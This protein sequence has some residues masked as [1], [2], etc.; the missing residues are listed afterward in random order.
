MKKILIVSTHI[1]PFAG[2]AE[3]VAWEIATGL[4]N[5]YEVH[6]LTTGPNHSDETS[7]GILI[8]R[9]KYQY[10]LSLYYSTLGKKYIDNLFLKHKFDLINI[11]IIPPWAYLLRKYPVKK[12]ITPHGILYKGK[13]G[14]SKLVDR[15]KMRKALC[16]ASVVTAGSKWVSEIIGSD[17]GINVMCIPNGVDLKRFHPGENKEKEN[18]ILFVGRYV[19]LKGIKY[20]VEAVKRLPQY[21]FWFAGRG[22]LDGI[23]KGENVRNMGF[24]D[25][26]EELMKEATICVFPSLLENAPMVGLEAMACG[27]PIIATNLGFSEFVEH[28]KN[29][30]IIESASTQ[31]I[32][33][34][35]D[36]LMNNADLRKTIGV[37]ARKTAEEYSWNRILEQYANLFGKIIDGQNR[38]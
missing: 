35:I 11:H 13:K 29:G 32:I 2:G 12:I 25:K 19:E 27:K 37:N 21:E 10:P 14:I 5:K 7:N 22:P 16:S 31:A 18:V 6:I 17:F 28:E 15:Y 36:R 24:C 34:G 4:Q 23:I 33:E 38:Q 3:R 20:L 30:L 1:P 26:P 9:V 8:H